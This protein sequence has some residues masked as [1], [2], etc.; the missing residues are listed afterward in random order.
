MSLNWY[1]GGGTE[2]AAHLLHLCCGDAAL[3]LEVFG[4]QA[5]AFGCRPVRTAHG[6]I[7][8]CLVHQVFRTDVLSVGASHLVFLFFPPMSG[9]S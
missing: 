2:H 1:V 9:D 7:K 3:A 4:Q 5:V 8:R 6:G